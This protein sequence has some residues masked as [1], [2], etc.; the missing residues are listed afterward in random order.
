MSMKFGC[1]P[2]AIEPPAAGSYPVAADNRWSWSGHSIWPRCT[3]GGGGTRME[4]MAERAHGR[5]RQ[6]RGG[7]GQPRRYRVPGQPLL[8]RHQVRGVSRSPDGLF[9]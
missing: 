6:H 7:P 8:N 2:L 3:P 9:A 4:R 5:Q 1:Q